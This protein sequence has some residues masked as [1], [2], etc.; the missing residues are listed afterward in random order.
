MVYSLLVTIARNW[1]VT[2]SIQDLKIFSRR[3]SGFVQLLAEIL[4]KN[5][6][7]LDMLYVGYNQR[8]MISYGSNKSQD[9][10]TKGATNNDP[11]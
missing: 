3:V 1:T 9:Y 2:E 4:T 10:A 8:V 6:H 7:A 11:P 5:S